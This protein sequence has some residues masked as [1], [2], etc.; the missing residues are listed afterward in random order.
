MPD[1]WE[2][3][4]PGPCDE[5]ALPR[6]NCVRYH[7][8]NANANFWIDFGLLSWRNISKSIVQSSARADCS[9]DDDDAHRTVHCGRTK[10]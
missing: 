6:Q 8:R 3:P 2:Y 7:K 5:Y 9:A 1:N 4:E 10:P